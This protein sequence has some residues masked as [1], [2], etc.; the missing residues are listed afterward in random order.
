M[1][2]LFKRQ[3]KKIGVFLVA[4]MLGFGA[5]PLEMTLAR[6]SEA[7]ETV[8][9]KELQ[10]VADVINRHYYKKVD[11]NGLM[12]DVINRATDK[13]PINTVLKNFVKK[14]G[15]PYSEYF[16]EEEWKSFNQSMEGKFY[17]IGVQVQKDKKTGGSYINRVFE[18]SPAKE[19]GLKKGDIIIKVA[20]KSVTKMKLEDV[21]KLIKGDSGTEVQIEVLRKKKKKSFMVERREVVVPSVESKYYQK[22]NIGYIQVSGFLDNTDEEFDKKLT[23]LEKNTLEGLI[24]DL[25]DNGGGYVD[26]ALQML[27][28]ILPNG[29]KVFSFQHS[30]GKT[31]DFYSDFE[32]RSVDQ[33]FEKPIIVLMNRNSASA[34]EIFA[35][36]LKD[37][38]AAEIV[39]EKSFGKGVA[40]NIFLASGDQVR[41]KVKVT[42]HYYLLPLGENIDKKGIAPNRVILNKKDKKGKLQDNQLKTAIKLLREKK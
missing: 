18:N 9:R 24:I 13:T 20:R 39:G 11:T 27:N 15:D 31:E 6:P 42:V 38:E 8:F 5:F 17:G 34:S 33:V 29:K 4:G 7:K 16:T 12:N 35:G 25:R 1:K 14:L 21:I 37:N 26:T 22:E 32:G 19:A 36:G 30:G 2:G 3:G 41:G 10:P 23:K 28:R 40:Q